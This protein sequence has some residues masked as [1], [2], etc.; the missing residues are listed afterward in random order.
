MAEKER[1]RGRE[2]AIKPMYAQATN[3]KQS[4][5]IVVMLAGGNLTDTAI[6]Y[7]EFRSPDEE[8]QLTGNYAVVDEKYDAWKG[9]D[10]YIVNLVLADLAGVEKAK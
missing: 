7:F 10:N 9:D 4:T 3:T 6:F 5:K 8:V 1:V 2:V